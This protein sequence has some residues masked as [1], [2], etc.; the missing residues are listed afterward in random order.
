MNREIAKRILE[1]GVEF[2]Q[3]NKVGVTATIVVMFLSL[4]LVNGMFFL[5]GLTNFFIE[6]IQNRVD[7]SVYFN[8]DASEKTVLGLKEKLDELPEVKKVQYVS[9]EETLSEFKEKHKNDDFLIQSLEEIG[10]NPFSASLDIKAYNPSDYGAIVNFIENSEY[11][12]YVEKVD[13]QE[14]QKVIKNLLKTTQNI[15]RLVLILIIL[16]GLTAILVAFNTLRLIIYNSREEIGIMRLVGASNWFIRGPFLVQGF[17]IGLISA[18]LAF[19]VF[20]LIS[21][22]VDSRMT[23]ILGGFSLAEFFKDNWIFILV[24][25]LVAAALLSCFS[26]VVALRKYL[27]K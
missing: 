13:Y 22:L 15:D 10:T 14:N 23:E 27:R 6:E 12:N 1:A 3:R 4:S 26:T 24:L 11:K 20:G 25:D 16:T 17:I 21:F 5:K 7:V 8:L 18:I 2:F 9:P 19:G